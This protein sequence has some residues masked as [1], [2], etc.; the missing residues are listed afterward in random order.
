MK[1]D[2]R[3]REL[4]DPT[5]IAIPVGFNR[6]ETLQEQIRRLVRNEFSQVAAATGFETF[7]EAN[8]FDV[9]DADAELHATEYEMDPEVPNGKAGF[10]R[11]QKGTEDADAG[12][13]AKG[14]D[15]ESDEP[16]R[17]GAKG[18]TPPGSGTPRPGP[19]DQVTPHGA[20]VPPRTA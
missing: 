16:T 7:D 3:G 6:P 10:E 20:A 8:D 18:Q 9:P 1:Y 14:D 13:K 15:V 12:G 11:P 4:P 5:P 19:G 17:P 2:E